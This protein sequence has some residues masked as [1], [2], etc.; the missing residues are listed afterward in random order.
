MELSICYNQF[1]LKVIAD[2]LNTH[3]EDSYQVTKR[4]DMKN[5]LVIIQNQLGEDYVVNQIPLSTQI[6]EWR[7]HNLLYVFGV[8]RKRTKDV[9]LNKESWWRRMCYTIL[10]LFY[11]T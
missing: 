8:Q 3:I 7:A 9:D 6:H 5:V 11:W 2:E 1:N 4:K 10:S